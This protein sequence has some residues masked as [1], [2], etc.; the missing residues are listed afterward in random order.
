MRQESRDPR[1]RQHPRAEGPSRQAARTDRNA[2]LAREYLEWQR[3]RNRSTETL[4]IYTDV[5]SKLLAWI[6][7]TPIAA[8]STST[9]EA[10]LDRPRKRRRPEHVRGEVIIGS[11]ATRRRD[12]TILRSFFRFISERGRIGHNPALLLV[13]PAV[14]NA[15]PLPVDDDIWR[16]VWSNPSLDPDERLLLGLG[17]FCGLRRREM[18]DLRPSHVDCGRHQIRGFVRKGGPSSSLAYRS[19]IVLLAD[20]LPELVPGGPRLFLD[21]LEN[22]ARQRQIHAY[23]FSWG[24]RLGR[25]DEAQ[26]RRGDRLDRYPPGWTPPGTLNKRLKTLLRRCGLPADSF[27][28]HALRH[29]FVTNLL[30]AGA[31]LHIVSRLAGHRDTNTTMRY[32]HTSEDPLAEIVGGIERPGRWLR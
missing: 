31:P 20:R 4:F 32:V 27:T 23:L 1:L 12:T 28:P 3:R 13:A 26:A 18:V 24:D 25:D 9:L 11:P 14:H 2:A 17:F 29:S 21:C 8:V 22:Q 15:E 10:F 16:A 30:R 6:G 5:L 19:P 7:E